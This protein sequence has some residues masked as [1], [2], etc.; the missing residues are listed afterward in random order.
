MKNIQFI[1]VALI[2]LLLTGCE[3][4]FQEPD[5]TSNIADSGVGTF[6]YDI[7]LPVDLMMAELTLKSTTKGSYT[8]KVDLLGENNNKG[9]FSYVPTGYYQ[10]T[11]YF[12]QE[13]LTAASATETVY[14]YKDQTTALAADFSD[15][16]FDDIPDPYSGTIQSYKITESGAFTLDNLT[17]NQVYAVAVNK[18]PTLLSYRY[19][20]GVESY[21]LNGVRH[22]VAMAGR[23]IDGRAF[24]VSNPGDS[25]ID[26]GDRIP[27]QYDK[28]EASEFNTNPPQVPASPQR[29]ARAIISAAPAVGD[30]RLFW[31]DDTD[32]TNT[33]KQKQATLVATSN[34]ANVW[35]LDDH[36]DNNSAS[37][38]DN[39]LTTAQAHAIAQKFDAIYQYTTPVFGYEYG[40]G[41]NSPQP[42]GVDEDPKIQILLYDIGGSGASGSTIGY[43]WSKDYYNDSYLQS[44][45]YSYRS[46]NAEIIYM[47]SYWADSRVETVYSALIHEFV[48]MIVH[49]EKNIKQ[50]LNYSTWYT[51][52]LA[53]LGED[54]I[55]PMIGIGPDSSGH[56]ISTR[57]PY[58]LGL[59]S[60]DPFY[61][62]GSRSYGVTYGFGA[63][64]ARNF[65]GPDL[66]RE[67]AQNNKANID[68]ISAALAVFSPDADFTQ[69]VERY[70]EAFIYN[71]YRD[72][73][74]MSF[75]RT[76]MG[77][78]GGY[79]YILYGFDIY[80]INRVNIA[81]GIGYVSYWSTTEKGP[82][83]YNITQNYSLDYYSFILLTCADWQ[84]ASGSMI[85]DLKKPSSSSVN[86]H[87]IVR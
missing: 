25:P 3:D 21:T 40:G 70:H 65:G 42:G 8:E 67:I 29:S 53:M 73:E 15:V 78:I 75:N 49:N 56:P 68:S 51:E 28:T 14:I 76:V 11:F 12:C 55:S 17:A 9:A 66:V 36:I 59:Y 2:L 22:Q 20:G 44:L 54:M 72:T 60:S 83:L 74:L 39:K 47:N 69:T 87:L 4:V 13:D 16:P 79:R 64:L 80:Q 58:T 46:N 71:G 85:V 61:W 6:T 7:T 18:S 57:I 82:F 30:K 84:N 38:T 48:H 10:I 26:E 35:I 43:F 32:K 63:Y 33:W 45:G 1:S 31:L 52:I 77:T 86:L 23:S 50:K 24:N 34:H 62:V 37:A 81:L 19:T 5:Q 27:L 41:S